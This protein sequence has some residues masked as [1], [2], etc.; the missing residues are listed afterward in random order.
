MFFNGIQ[1]G[2]E[3][4]QKSIQM[5]TAYEYCFNSKQKATIKGKGS[6]KF[7]F[8]LETVT[9]YCKKILQFII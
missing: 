5:N 9:F 7:L 6:Y 1:Y 3:T 4:F 8:S 2:Y